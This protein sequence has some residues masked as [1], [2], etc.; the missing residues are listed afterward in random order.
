MARVCFVTGKKPTSGGHVSYA[1]NQTRQ[2]FEPKLLWTRIWIPS[3]NRFVRLQM[4]ARGLK[5]I[6]KFGIERVL[7]AAGN[8]GRER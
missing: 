5:T 2:R 4:C 8:G 1:N 7:A 6:S 3:E